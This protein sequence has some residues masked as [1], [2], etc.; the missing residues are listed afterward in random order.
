MKNCKFQK[1]EDGTPV[2]TEVVIDQ[3]FA[4][5]KEAKKQ[6]Y[7]SK[8]QSD[9]TNHV[10]DGSVVPSDYTLLSWD[11]VVAIEENGWSFKQQGV[12][13]NNVKVNL[14]KKE[15]TFDMMKNIHHTHNQMSNEKCRKKKKMLLDS[16]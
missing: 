13:E 5:L 15:I 14:G 12:V 4:E 16:Q 1:K 3:K 8:N 7:V 2:N 6:L 11:N 10:M 9:G